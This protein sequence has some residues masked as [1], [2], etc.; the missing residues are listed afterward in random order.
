MTC[1]QSEVQRAEPGD[2]IHV[3]TTSGQKIRGTVVE[4]DPD[5]E[6]LDSLTCVYRL[7]AMGRQSAPITVEIVNTG[8][9][10]V[11]H[12]RYAPNAN[13]ETACVVG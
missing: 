2:E 6:D 8:R 11:Q 1:T 4:T 3:A 13:V 7:R 5:P 12:G 10:R 9:V